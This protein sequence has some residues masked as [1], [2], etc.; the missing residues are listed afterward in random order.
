[1]VTIFIGIIINCGTIL[2]ESTAKNALSYININQSA[3]MKTS[4]ANATIIQ[5]RTNLIT[6]SLFVNSPSFLYSINP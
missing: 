5:E 4:T 2:T 1:M 6:N 3:F